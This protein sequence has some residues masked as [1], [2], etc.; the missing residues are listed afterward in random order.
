MHVFTRSMWSGVAA[1]LLGRVASGSGQASGWVR[2]LMPGRLS[3]SGCEVPAC[4]F[5]HSYLCSAIW[6]AGF[7]VLGLGFVEIVR[8]SVIQGLWI[9]GVVRIDA[10]RSE[11]GWPTGLRD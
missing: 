11:T 9:L 7:A 10:A 4:P 3:W 6:S 5:A 8:K 2:W 1:A